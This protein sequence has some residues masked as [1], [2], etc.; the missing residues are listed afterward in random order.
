LTKFLPAILM[1]LKEQ[2]AAVILAVKGALP[3]VRA[4]AAAEAVVV[5]Q[6]D[7]AAPEVEFSGGHC[8]GEPSRVLSLPPTTMTTKL[9][10]PRHLNK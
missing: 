7:A 10:A 9:P 5:A 3:A 2:V 1:P 4:P 6:V 8:L